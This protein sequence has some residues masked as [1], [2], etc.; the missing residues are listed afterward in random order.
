MW[1][2]IF[3]VITNGLIASDHDPVEITISFPTTTPCK[4]ITRFTGI[5]NKSLK[6]F[7]H[8]VFLSMKHTPN[9]ILAFQETMIKAANECFQNQT[10]SWRT[11]D[12]LNTREIK[13]TREQLKQNFRY[14]K[15]IK[16]PGKQWSSNF[17][18]KTNLTA[19]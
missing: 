2:Q 13:D 6:N 14:L 5:S 9:D 7:S 16:H 18:P 19:E 12:I 4:S 11:P 17:I 10:T 1:S 15:F 3:R 8:R